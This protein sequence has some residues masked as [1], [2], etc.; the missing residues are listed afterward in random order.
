MVVVKN[1]E[2]ERGLWVEGA[3]EQ[4]WYLRAIGPPISFRLCVSL[5]LINRSFVTPSRHVTSPI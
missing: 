2:D 5:L 4:A 3:R 1:K